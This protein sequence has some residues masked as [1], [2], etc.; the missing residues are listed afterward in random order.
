MS[1]R[2]MLSGLVVGAVAL[3]WAAV[4]AASPSGVVISQVYGGGGNAGATYTHDFIELYNAG[5]ESVPLSGWSVQYGSS[6]GTTW[7]NRT[8]L[9][10]SIA[11]GRYLLI[12]QAAGAGGTTALPE[13]DITGNINMSGSAGKVAL[14]RS[15]E[16][17]TGTG[18]P[19]AAVVE[20]F[21]GYGSVNCSEGLSAPG[22]SNETAALRAANG[23]IDT[24][25]NRTDFAAGA[26]NPRNSRFG[27]D[28]VTLSIDDVSV[29]EGDSGTTEATFTVSLSGAAGAGGVTFDV[30]TAD[31]TATV[32]DGDYVAKALTGQSI[33]AGG[34]SAPFTVAVN[35]DGAFEDDETF[36]VDVSN[37]TG[38]TVSDGRG[39]GTIQNDD[40]DCTTPYTRIPSI[41]GE[42][43][44]AAITGNV[45]TQGVVVGDFEGSAGLSGF[46]LQDVAGDGNAA[47]SDGIFVY[48]GSA[49]TVSAG[50]V[51]RVTGFARERFNQTAINGSNSNNA[52][53]TNV[54]A[55]GPSTSVPATDVSMPFSAT[56]A[57]ERYEGMLVRFPQPLVIS[58]YFNYER[59][60]ELVLALPL[61][62]ESRAFTPTSI[63]APGGPALARLQANLLRRITLDDALA[64]QNPPVLRHPNGD[65]F[66]L[67]NRFR[68]G[69]TVA[70][71]VGVIG[72][73]F[74]LYR[75]YPT[76]D[77][78]YTAVNPR[79]AG[80]PDV[81]GGL[82]VAA[83]NTLNFFITGDYA[84]SDPR[85]NGCGPARNVECR[86]H[87]ADQ[88]AEF[89]RQRDKLIA[90]LA[91][92][93]ADVTG[94]NEVENTAGVDP[95]SDPDGIVPGLNATLGAG[96]YAAIDTGVIGTDAIRVGLIY[97]PA[98][99]TPVGPFKLLTTAVDPRFIDTKSRPVLAQTF[100]VNATGARFTVAV[101]HLKSKGSDCNDV[102]DPDAGDGQ[103]NCNA[104]REAAAEALVD[105]LGTDPTGSGDPDFLIVGDLNSYAQEDPIKAIEAGSDDTAGTSDDYVN[106][107]ARELGTYAYSYVFDGMSGYL[108]HAL[109]NTAIA[110]QVAGVAEWHIN[111]DEPDVF[112]Y[113]TSFKPAAQDALYEPNAFR[114]SD[115]DPVLVGL[116]LEATFAD[117]R[118]LTAA[119]VEHPGIENSLLAKLAAAQAAA[120][121]GN[122]TAKQNILGAYANEVEAQTGKALT[123]AQ[124]A[125]LLSIA[126]SL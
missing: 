125:Q 36:F 108:D 13:A 6:G 27:D 43:A 90:A 109:G 57:P 73:D 46:Y 48:T 14:V 11:P 23:G 92:L 35:G 115:H 12:K 97:K 98:T 2:G 88:P 51:V 38:A 100:E 70:N 41:Q 22:L 103:G 32:A 107:V 102:G 59:F 71:A 110:S 95:L 75:I 111:A 17:L 58:E 3:V 96:T 15:I 63:D 64:A 120:E 82:R 4:A 113:D 105:W 68:G 8:N 50:Q 49:D 54:V 99:V 104:T 101:N 116:D 29:A 31:G 67:T 77:A 81:A 117:L 24:D 84:S 83:M 56:D 9:S 85:D 123:P 1:F 65:A 28:G 74:S 53:V 60:G 69:D 19:F 72:F 26:P 34:T 89:S 40:V 91:G 10:G 76:A 21:V 78:D 80:S 16:P 62:G 42:D 30:A 20:D 33:P 119:Y 61:A 7:N 5:T 94:L 18:C 122:E 118:R 45:T 126:R 66:S 86:G 79:P 114:S 25:N 44:N 39:A 93:D 47:T 52:A 121:R 37:V 124:A 55:C 112:D 87:D 106:L